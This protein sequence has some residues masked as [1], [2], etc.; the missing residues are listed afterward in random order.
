MIQEERVHTLNDEEISGAGAYVLYW[1][2]HPQRASVNHA[3]EFAIREAN[4]RGLPLLAVFGITQRFPEANTRSYAFMLEGLR[5]ARQ[6]LRERGVRL[7][8]RLQPPVEAVADLAADAAL[9]VVDRGYLRVERRWRERVA[10]R[11]SCPLVQVET[12]VVVPVE[13]ASQKE[14]YAAYTIRPKIHKHLDAFLVPLE[15]TALRRDSLGLT[16]DGLGLDDIEARLGRMRIN[17]SAE[18][19]D[20]FLGGSSQARMLLDDFIVHKLDSY[21]EERNDPVQDCLSHMSPYLHF[22]QISPLEVAL[23]VRGARGVGQENKDAYLEE[24]VVRRE[25]SMNLCVFN[26]HYD[27]LACVPDWARETLEEHAGDQREHVYDLE[28]FESA[29]TH[30]PYWNAAQREM[31]LTGKMH[32]YMRMYWGKKILEWTPSPERGFAIALELNN[33]YELDGRD[34]NGFTGVAWCF[35]K[36]DHAW[37]ER[38]VYGKV[39]YMSAGG[40]ERKFDIDAYVQ[41]VERLRSSQSQKGGV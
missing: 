13:T 25:L 1:M 29:R 35:G 3:L 33:R 16:F 32:G 20:T 41:K 23:K 5:E 6:A 24:L 7:V 17:R 21:A 26:P 18:R 12:D 27:S 2:Q 14:E 19:V 11:L 37:A 40:L 28:Q 9:V 31:V 30:D 34:P 38:Q 10:R 39:R 15:E 4:R 8:V 22:G 36:H